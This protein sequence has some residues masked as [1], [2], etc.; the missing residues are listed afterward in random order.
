MKKIINGKRYDT[1]TAKLMA[2]WENNVAYGNFRH[3]SEDLYQ[4]RT[5]EFFLHGYGGPAS[6]YAKD[7]YS[8]GRTGGEAIVPISY[9]EALRWAEQK[10]TVDEYEEIFGVVE[11]DDSKKMVTFYISTYHHEN[12]KRLGAETGRAMSDLIEIAIDDLMD[13][14][15]DGLKEEPRSTHALIDNAQRIDHHAKTILKKAIDKG[16]LN[17]GDDAL[18]LFEEWL[19][20]GEVLNRKPVFF[21]GYTRETYLDWWREEYQY[22]VENGE[23]LPNLDDAQWFY[24]SENGV[25]EFSDKPN[26]L[27]C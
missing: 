6:P 5:G 2:T 26:W 12:L 3:Y 21:G 4:K 15:P 19:D 8:G 1:N 20:R 11:E 22:L 24:V 7:A 18:N 23:E 9:A 27:N 14:P 16:D 17:V 25:I 10:L 13:M